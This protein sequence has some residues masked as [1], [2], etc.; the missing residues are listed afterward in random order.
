[1]QHVSP[2]VQNYLEDAHVPY[3]VLQ[4]SLSQ[5]S[6]DTACAAHVPT[7]QMIKSIVLRDHMDGRYVIA[8]IPA[9]HKLKLRWVNET[10]GRDLVLAQEQELQELMPDCMTGAVPALGQA[11]GLD[12]I[13]ENE[14]QNQRELFFEGGDHE[15]LVQIS[16]QE[17]LKLFD[18]EPMG[19]ISM[20]V[21][22]YSLYHADE[23]RS[24]L[25]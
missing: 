20:P 11:Y 12:V 10:L 24:S 15:Q 22:Q 6:Y 19:I 1:M 23:L 21:E 18:E 25:L 4:H 3:G 5:S 13:W 17:F 8:L 2:S 14:L 16:P 9:S 7:A